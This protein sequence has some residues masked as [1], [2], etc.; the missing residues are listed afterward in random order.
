MGNCFSLCKSYNCLAIDDDWRNRPLHE[1]NAND[2]RNFLR[3]EGYEDWEVHFSRYN[4]RNLV[5][6]LTEG[7][8]AEEI[9]LDP[10]RARDLI[11]LINRYRSQDVPAIPP[12]VATPPA[13]TDQPVVATPPVAEE[14][15]PAGGGG[16]V[17]RTIHIPEEDEDDDTEEDEDDDTEDLDPI[18][19]LT[20]FDGVVEKRVL[21]GEYMM[22]SVRRTSVPDQ[23]GEYLCYVQSIP[24]SYNGSCRVESIIRVHLAMFEKPIWYNHQDINVYIQQSEDALNQLR[25]ASWNARCAAQFKN[26]P[27]ERDA[28]RNRMKTFARVICLS[29]CDVVALQEM[30]SVVHKGAMKNLKNAVT[31]KQQLNDDLPLPIFWVEIEKMLLDALQELSLEEWGSEANEVF[32]NNPIGNQGPNR[33]IHTFIY[34]KSRVR[35]SGSKRILDPVHRNRALQRTPVLGYFHSIRFPESG[36]FTLCNLHI[37]PS[38][39]AEPRRHSIEV[40]RIGNMIEHIERDHSIG[41]LIFLGDMNISS[42]TPRSFRP[43]SEVTYVINDDDEYTGIVGDDRPAIITCTVTHDGFQHE[44]SKRKI[45]NTRIRYTDEEEH[46]L[47]QQKYYNN[48]VDVDENH[49]QPTPEEETWDKFVRRGYIPCIQD[50]FTNTKKTHSYDNI[51]INRRL[52]SHRP[53]LNDVPPQGRPPPYTADNERPLKIITDT[54]RLQL[55]YVPGAPLDPWRS[56]LKRTPFENFRRGVFEHKHVLPVGDNGVSDHNLVFMDVKLMEDVRS[57]I[58]INVV[59]EPP[60]YSPGKCKSTTSST[61][62]SP[63]A[64]DT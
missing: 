31:G 56:H 12:V 61:G 58:E 46:R 4:G 34:K 48:S 53:Q 45:N 1:W 27:I 13:V 32:Y 28:L 37:K 25:I 63:N 18:T 20:V 22:F 41:E 47:F 59:P 50:C 29:E 42:Q 62:T 5:E 64:T 16:V 40:Q 51:W 7:N 21:R 43:G 26:A 14:Q 36:Q 9:N 60:P 11:G 38:L 30:P 52:D 10:F 2:V 57:D 44:V 39:Q 54:V 19:T 23:N 55:S 33:N 6:R 8:I 35:C 15:P 49:F 17:D 24:P 3:A